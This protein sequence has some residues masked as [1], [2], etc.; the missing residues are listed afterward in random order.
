MALGTL[1]QGDCVI[2]SV[3]KTQLEA[4]MKGSFIEAGAADGGTDSNT[5]VLERT[6]G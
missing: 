3:L 1:A 4:G 6:Y 2:S 5:L